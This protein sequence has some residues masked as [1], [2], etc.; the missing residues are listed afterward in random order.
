MEQIKVSDLATEFNIQYTIVISELKKIGV[1]VPSA[2]TPVD[3]DIAIRIRRRLQFMADSE[4]EELAKAEKAKEKKVVAA[5]AKKTIKELGTPRRQVAKKPEEKP[6]ETALT[7]SLKPRRGR[8]V[9][10]R[11]EEEAGIETAAVE[12]HPFEAPDQAAVPPPVEVEASVEA[13]PPVPEP[14]PEP[15]QEVGA[16]A[17]ETPAVESVVAKEEPQPAP[18]PATEVP[19]VS[20]PAPASAK[21]AA[22]P[23]PAVT[24]PAAAPVTQPYPTREKPAGKPAI[25][26]QTAPEPTVITPAKVIRP[27]VRPP[28]EQRRAPVQPP[29]PPVRPGRP[30]VV[31][32]ARPAAAPPVAKAPEPPREKR[33]IT[34]PESVS[35][36]ELCE[37]LGVKSKDLLRELLSRGIMAAINQ[38][39]DQKTIIDVCAAFNA[40]ARFVTFEEAAVEEGKLEEKPADLT[41]RAPV[42]TV[43][44]HVDHGKT[45][46]LDAIRKT[47]VAAGEAGGITQHMGAYHVNVNNRRIV[48][49]DTP[50]HEAFT[51]MR[52][53]GARAT[54]IVV[55]VV[56]A[57]DGVMPQTV[58]AI[59]HARA[60]GVPI[61]VAINKIDKPEA[62][63]QRVKQELTK[64]D[65]LAEEWGGQTVTV[66]V[67]AR[68]ETNLDL[69][70]EMILL[71]AD[72]LELKANPKRSAT[73]VVL[74]ARL[75]KGRGAV[76]TVLV[77]NGTLRVGDSFIAGAAYG[78]IRAMFDDRGD[79]VIE[80]GPSSAVEVLGLQTLPQAGDSFQ[81]VDDTL[82]ARQIGEYRQTKLREK[83]LVK[84]SRVSLDEL[85]AQLQAGEVKELPIVL[86]ADA[87]GSV[88]VLEDTLQKL[89]TDK[90]KIRIIHR[91]VG[92]ISESDVLLASA[93]NAIVIGFNV[94]PEQNAQA[95]AEHEEVDIRLYTVI[96]DVS[97]EIKQAMLGLLEPT[98]KESYQGRAEVRQTFRVPK[99]GTVAGS[100]VLDGTVTRN[101][102][103]RLLR[104]N[105]VVY[106]GRVGSLRRFKED[107]PQVKAGYEC[108]IAIAN[109][110]DVKVGDVIEAFVKERVEPQL[111]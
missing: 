68:E 32:G 37:K 24:A 73:G 87:Q 14:T 85:Y 38:T 31:K 70:L 92:A 33:D 17:P 4:Q 111:A 8:G 1:W 58:E 34:L 11:P 95:A 42:V 28:H 15:A 94:R 7:S 41:P 75:D 55:L 27:V 52:A 29:R 48:F 62:D 43:M 50:G 90:V 60:A 99:F 23:A 3:P 88:E 49:L 9:Y 81:V 25:L 106:E 47:K 65:L 19:T 16:P 102:E 84:S 83:E 20:A 5:K 96:Y 18:E 86:K 13:P 105:V 71:V 107:V 64:Y 26:K 63:P 109:F 22:P 100:Y 103:V 45:S 40:T 80:V 57:D 44:G 97:N 10:R 72:M 91:G 93:S 21:A 12:A 39:L 59:N 30:H 36:K 6:V 2:D 77:Q 89:S 108:G 74:E 35:V 110:N 101:S 61:V 69:L 54:D 56:A 78:K 67:S 79:P 76:A 66:E 51:M 82:K 104:D 98:V 53:R 46:L